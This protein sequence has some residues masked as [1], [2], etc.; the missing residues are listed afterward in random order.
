LFDAGYLDR[1]EIAAVL[2]QTPL[3]TKMTTDAPAAQA[4]QQSEQLPQ[5][6]ETDIAVAEAPPSNPA[7]IIEA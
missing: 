2:A 6:G 7:F 4:A 3:P 1:G 5:R